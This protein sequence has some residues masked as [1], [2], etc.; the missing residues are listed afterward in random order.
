MYYQLMKTT[1]R[2]KRR[3][4]ISS[5]GC[6]LLRKGKLNSHQEITDLNRWRDHSQCNS[7]GITERILVKHGPQNQ[8]TVTQEK[9][10]GA[11]D[12]FSR[13]MLLEKTSPVVWDFGEIRNKCKYVMS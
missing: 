3:R 7:T 2:S 1:A 4:Y 8:A 9:T 12:L 6:L 5:E 11:K 13:E 10:R